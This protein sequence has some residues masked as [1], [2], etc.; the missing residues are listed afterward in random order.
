MEYGVIIRYVTVA[1]IATG[2]NRVGDRGN[3]GFKGKVCRKLLPSIE[4]VHY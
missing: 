3:Y 2:W 1:G 4:Q